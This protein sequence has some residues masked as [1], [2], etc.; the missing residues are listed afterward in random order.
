[1]IV[2]CQEQIFFP[3]FSDSFQ[4]NLKKFMAVKVFHCTK[5]YYYLKRKE[6]RKTRQNK[7]IIQ[8]RMCAMGI[9][10]VTDE[11]FFLSSLNFDEYQ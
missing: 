6:S 2:E 3:F 8:I 11:R 1:M 10:C 5:Q 4:K 9:L 7:R